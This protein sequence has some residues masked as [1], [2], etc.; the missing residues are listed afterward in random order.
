MDTDSNLIFESY[1]DGITQKKRELAGNIMDIIRYGLPEEGQIPGLV[2]ELKK[3]FK[4]VKPLQG[5]TQTSEYQKAIG[6]ARRIMGKLKAAGWKKPQFVELYKTCD[7]EE[8]KPVKQEDDESV[9][10]SSSFNFFSDKSRNEEAENKFTDN[11]PVTKYLVGKLQ[12]MHGHLEEMST[13]IGFSKNPEIDQ[14]LSKIRDLAD[15]LITE[16]PNN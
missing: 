9:S 3:I 7:K 11:K 10:T 1:V 6:E 13:A 2:E 12:Q 5:N 14:L 16:Q 8:E 15:M 4:F